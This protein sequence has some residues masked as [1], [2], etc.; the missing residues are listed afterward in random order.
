MTQ[1]LK[2][3]VVGAGIVGVSVAEYLRRGGHQVTLVDRVAPGDP[4]QA[5]YGNAG[6]IAACSV[7][8]VPVPSLLPRI[9]RFLLDPEAP[10]FMRWRY[11]PRIS[12]WLIQFLSGAKRK[13]VESRAAALASLTFDSLTEHL[14]L[15]RGTGAAKYIRQSDWYFVYPDL[16]SFE[17]DSF[18]REVRHSN[19]FPHRVLS[20]E[21]II[22]LDAGVSERYVFGAAHPDHGYITDPGEFVAE[23]AAHFLRNGG[24]ALRAEAR[25]VIPL[26]GGRAALETSAG[27]IDADRAV[28]SAGIWSGR[29]MKQLGYA[30]R[31]QSERGYHLTLK[32]ASPAV[33]VP[34]MLAD[35][36]AAVTPMKRG[37]RIAG[38]VEFAS[39]E[40]D[41]SP[42][43]IRFLRKCIRRT[44]PRLTWDGEES[45]MG[46]RPTTVDCLPVVGA[47]P[48][49]PGILFAFG[50]QHVG[51]TCGPRIGRLLTELVTERKSNVDLSPFRVDRFGRI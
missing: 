37:L 44:F 23:L 14:L 45:W 27:R 33:P 40:A 31:M 2:I 29:W 24:S 32:N 21:D 50:T 19:G 3:V 41:P 10:V 12:P 34:F 9:P 26:E 42:Q 25:A 30:S 17:R 36:G 28:V 35:S 13:T 49:A 39:L 15:A 47:A 46:H 20:R 4:T 1:S 22:N 8:P 5:S 18:P 7:I 11:F 48:N 51:L 43:P 16:V 6:V 38:L